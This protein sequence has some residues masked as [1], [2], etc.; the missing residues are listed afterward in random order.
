MDVQ[1]QST[2]TLGCLY[3]VKSGN[4]VCEHYTILQSLAN[5]KG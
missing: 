5:S 4:C 2:G 1:S 3:L